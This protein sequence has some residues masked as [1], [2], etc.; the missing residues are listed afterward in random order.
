MGCPAADLGCGTGGPGL[1]IARATG[2]ALIGID[3]SPVAVE[4]ARQRSVRW[5]LADRAQFQVGDLQAT[6]VNTVSLDGAMSVDTLHFAPQKAAA[7]AE[8]ARI[9]RPGARVVRTTWD[10]TGTPPD[11]PPQVADR[12]PVLTDA[13]LVEA[14]EETPD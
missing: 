12:Q 2:A 8:I 9:L 14:Y 11:R 3:L 13:G 10:F 5:G 7:L 4:H 1:W 6:G